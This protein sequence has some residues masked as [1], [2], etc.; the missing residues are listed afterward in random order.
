MI[1]ENRLT[2]FKSVTES[3]CEVVLHGRFVLKTLI[4]GLKVHLNFSSNLSL[5]ELKT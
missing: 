2:D 3:F 1:V 4:T 5:S